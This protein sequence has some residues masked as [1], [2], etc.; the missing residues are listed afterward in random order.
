MRIQFEDVISTMTGKLEKHGAPKEKARTVAYEMATNSLEGTYTHGINRFARLIRAIDSSIVH[1]DANPELIASFAAIERYEGNLGFGITNALFAMDRAVEL[2]REH[3]IGMVGLRNTNHWMRAA[4]YGYRAVRQ[5][6]AAMCFTNTIPNMPAW[7]AL[8]S[9]LGNNPF[10]M[11][12]PRK[13][14][15]HIIVDSA[16]TQFSYGALEVAKMEGR[17]MSVPAGYDRNGNLTADPSAV[18]E[19]RRTIPSGYWKGSAMSFLLDIFASCLSLGR[20]V[21]DIAKLDG[22]EHG[23]SQLFF[24]I[25]YEKIVDREEASDTAERAIAFLKESTK[26][27]GV[28]E[29]VYPGERM[30]RTRERNLKEGIPV[31]DNVWNGILSL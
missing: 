4:T 18:L 3:G 25:D 27:E 26:A 22:D 6:C 9:K 14:G 1:P 20:A 24:A 13:D 19:T 17:M 5:G 21:A 23:V 11:A 7:G 31:D 10:V 15:R 29:I 12:F 28:N 30:M 16:M 2:A 8:D